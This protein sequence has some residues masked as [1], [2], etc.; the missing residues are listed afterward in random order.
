M[1]LQKIRIGELLIEK[2]LIT[3]AQVK[4]A[5]EEQ[6][7]SGDK[8]G[9]VFIKLGYISEDKL[10]DILAAQL[11]IHKIKA[12][13]IQI[14]SDLKFII[15]ENRAKQ[16]EILPVKIEPD[17]IHIATND[18]LNIFAIDEAQR[19]SKREV[20]P[21]I[22]SKDDF[23][24]V[25]SK[26]Y[27]TGDKL[28]K[29]AK[30]IEQKISSSG[31]DSKFLEKLAE[32]A[33]VIN[34]VDSFIVKAI[35]EKAS[36]I[37]IE[38]EEDMLRIRYRVDGIL[39]EV[40][41]LK[42]VLYSPI[43]SRI[44]ILSNMNIAEKRVPQDGRFKIIYNNKDVDFRVSTL[45]TSFGE[46]I[47]LR[48]LDKSQE[49]LDFKNLGIDEY[50]YKIYEKI[51]AHPYGIVLIS[52][53]TGSG[54]TTTLYA[55]LNKLNTIEKNII[56]VEDPIEYKFKL[57]NQVQV[58]E[59]AD[60]TFANSLRSILRQDPDIIMIGEIR[61]KETAEI[62]IQASL[63]GHLVLSTI[64]TNDAVSS[65]ARL[66]DM[67]IENFLVSSSVIGVGSQ[68][69]VRRIC[70]NC[71]EAYTPAPEILDRLSLPKDG[72]LQFYR[73]RGCD[74]CSGSGYKG[75]ISVFE[76]LKMTS[77]IKDAINRNESISFI[78]KL[79][80]SQ[81]FR[82]MFNNGINLVKEGVTTLE[83]ILRVTTIEE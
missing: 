53:P 37:H 13:D 11:Q 61:D 7:K 14:T 74:K 64:H 19:I 34:L 48:I 27:G 2:R 81:G 22:I 26:I 33:P 72:N 32:D 35:G 79:A 38:A 20:I 45:P 46:K 80:I 41:T 52:G 24:I 49:L 78:K 60:L 56:T 42:K 29:I 82:P 70:E 25:Y 68:R 55:T 65:V 69:L 67:G 76:I 71:K 47:V 18:P 28:Y 75:R 3:E 50:N 10:L 21:Y 43:I 77:E 9:S 30:D 57:I 15:P 40:I 17:Y 44:K 58:D 54:K 63:T 5:L 6:K 8:L 51:I 62:A 31:T 73:G 59:K 12:E 39:K 83:E 23:I 66:I 16:L 1:K 36:D 4:L